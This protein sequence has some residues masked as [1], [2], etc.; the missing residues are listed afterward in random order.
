VKWLDSR[1][2]GA[3]QILSLEKGAPLTEAEK[4]GN[5]ALTFDIGD[6]QHVDIRPPPPLEQLISFASSAQFWLDL[7]RQKHV[8]MVCIGTTSSPVALLFLS[9]LLVSTGA[10][11]NMS[12]ALQYLADLGR[13]PV[14]FKDV[15]QWAPS[16]RRY[17][18]YFQSLYSQ[19]RRKQGVECSEF[20]LKNVFVEKFTPGL[21]LELEVFEITDD[22][23]D[24]T[25]DTPNG[26][27]R[28]KRQAD[29]S[30][31]E[32]I[33]SDPASGM[34]TLDMTRHGSY[35]VVLRGDVGLVIKSRQDKRI[36]CRYFFHT[37]FLSE[38]QSDMLTLTKA[39][40][41]IPDDVKEKIPNDFQVKIV[42]CRPKFR[43]EQ[44]HIL[45]HKES[46]KIKR[47][48]VPTADKRQF[49]WRHMVNI[50]RDDVVKELEA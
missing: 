44:G 11:P 35:R 6:P 13:G 37:G 23:T 47:Y 15:N 33:T 20:E 39:D 40:F 26:G 19:Q 18:N 50:T 45:Q 29:P 9:C 32:V 21:V 41:D 3:Y 14:E 22:F 46:M 25:N 28:T 16:L 24:D 27:L 8:I 34:W 49:I 7:E 5:Q 17:M 10:C 38:G 1:H 42:L 48:K 2:E 43:D 4:L 30:L 36:S 12:Q 31:Y